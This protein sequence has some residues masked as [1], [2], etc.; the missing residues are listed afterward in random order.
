MIESYRLPNPKPR[1]SGKIAAWLVVVVILTL[2]Q[3]D[4]AA[5]GDDGTAHGRRDD[6]ATAAELTSLAEAGDARAQYLLGEMYLQGRGV[7]RDDEK[8][9]ALVTSAAEQ[10]YASAQYRLGRIVMSTPGPFMRTYNE[11][12]AWFRKAAEQ[13]HE[14]AKVMYGTYLLVSR[15][16]K[17]RAAGRA[18]VQKA[19]E[20]GNPNA[21]Y[22]LAV[23]YTVPWDGS[24]DMDS[25][26]FWF[27][28][29]AEKGHVGSL[30]ELCVRYEAGDSVRAMRESGDVIPRDPLI[31]Y[32]WCFILQV[33][34]FPGAV[35]RL[36]EAEKSLTGEQREAG[37]QKA[38]A[39]M[40]EHG[41][42]PKR[43]QDLGMLIGGLEACGYMMPRSNV[44]IEESIRGTSTDQSI[45]EARVEEFRQSQQAGRERIGRS[46]D[47]RSACVI[48][49]R[50]IPDDSSVVG[51][52]I[53]GEL[54]D[55]L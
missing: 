27:E 43:A 5:W 29:A 13:G 14:E 50:S 12:A 54:R 23:H 24:P 20:N 25:A 32:K 16:S 6:T 55:Q 7:R 18:L 41:L 28:R 22:A 11:A 39:F 1:S 52:V 3:I 47:K 38:Y 30:R 21:A 53:R 45:V 51:Q 19:A 35:P 31:A 40:R 44:M 42:R 36:V 49:A 4:R 34:N 8:G 2:P 26:I 37:E 15:D 48:L 17:Q 33:V 46:I 10:G 9:V